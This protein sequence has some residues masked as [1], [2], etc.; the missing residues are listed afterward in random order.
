MRKMRFEWAAQSDGCGVTFDPRFV[1]AVGGTN[2]HNAM[3]DG[4]NSGDSFKCCREGELCG[5]SALGRPIV[6]V[7]RAASGRGGQCK[8][9]AYETIACEEQ[10]PRQGSLDDAAGAETNTIATQRKTWP[11]WP[12]GQPLCCDTA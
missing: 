10:A 3:N 12:P 6:Y 5:A 1:Y 4:G 8:T 2:K 9:G 11:A 7:G